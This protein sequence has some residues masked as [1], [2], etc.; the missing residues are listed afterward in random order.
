MMQLVGAYSRRRGDSVDLR[1]G[2]PALGDERDGAA[3]DCVVG[4]G[5]VERIRV[6]SP[7]GREHARFHGFAGYLSRRRGFAHP[8]SEIPNQIPCGSALAWLRRVLPIT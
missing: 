7:I 8:I 4:G 3:H 1:L 6:A 2:A 5:A